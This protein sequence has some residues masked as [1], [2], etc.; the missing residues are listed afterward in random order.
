VHH[1]KADAKG[2]LYLQFCPD[3]DDREAYLG[4]GPDSPETRFDVLPVYTRPGKLDPNLARYAF[5]YRAP[6]SLEPGK[7]K[8]VKWIIRDK[9]GI[10]ELTNKIKDSCMVT[11][12]DMPK[13]DGSFKIVIEREATDEE[14][15]KEASRTMVFVELKVDD[16]MLKEG[17]IKRARDKGQIAQVQG[18]MEFIAFKLAKPLEVR[19]IFHSSINLITCGMTK[20]MM[21]VVQCFLHEIVYSMIGRPYEPGFWEI[22]GPKLVGSQVENV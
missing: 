10:A 18:F 14:K 3:D 12:R 17:D 2:G 16:S 5:F 8:W 7:G 4:V 13:N 21:Y 1:P 15:K 11:L 19:F 9:E 22:Y 20:D 6:S